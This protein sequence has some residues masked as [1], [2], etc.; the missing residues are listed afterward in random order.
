MVAQ[1]LDRGAGCPSRRAKAI[2]AQS[3]VV[4]DGSTITSTPIVSVSATGM[5][6]ISPSEHRYHRFGDL[7]H[8]HALGA[9]AVEETV[10][11]RPAGGC[12][13]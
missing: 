2:G 11:E 5:R 3:A 9:G 10:D 7:A 8:R 4:V 6:S 13:D 1:D 12:W